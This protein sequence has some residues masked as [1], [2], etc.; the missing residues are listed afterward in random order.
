[1]PT[2]NQLHKKQLELPESRKISFGEIS[3]EMIEEFGTEFERCVLMALVKRDGKV[4]VPGKYI[5]EVIMEAEHASYCGDA[6]QIEY[7]E[8]SDQGLVVVE[9]DNER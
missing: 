7:W 9:S 8:R 1:M 3:K 5:R 4:V 6:P 2:A